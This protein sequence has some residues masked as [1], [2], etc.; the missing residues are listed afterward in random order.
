MSEDVIS[1]A[2]AFG[3]GGG[4][5]FLGYDYRQWQFWSIYTPIIICI[6]LLSN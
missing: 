5:Y 4:L 3:L 2:A 1:I 6:A